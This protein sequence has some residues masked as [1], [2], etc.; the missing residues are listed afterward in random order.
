MHH[1]FTKNESPRGYRYRGQTC[2]RNLNIMQLCPALFI[3]STQIHWF[4]AFTFRCVCASVQQVQPWPTRV[5]ASGVV[6][7][8]VAAARWRVDCRLA[9]RD[10][11][12][13][14]RFFQL[15]QLVKHDILAALRH[16]NE[17]VDSRCHKVFRKWIYYGRGHKWYRIMI[18]LP[19]ATFSL[20]WRHRGEVW[21]LSINTPHEDLI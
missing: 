3:Q 2:C 12:K 21:P 4:S 15:S 20:P 9:V 17:D 1:K 11:R 10:A 18:S 8:A 19:P 13:K 7:T 14:S 16:S 6:C 5:S